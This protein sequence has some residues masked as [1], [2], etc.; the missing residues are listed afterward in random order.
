MLTTGKLGLD[1]GSDELAPRMTE[2]S[3]FPL[4]LRNIWLIWYP[5]WMNF[6]LRAQARHARVVHPNPE[7]DAISS[8]ASNQ[9]E[10]IVR[11]ILML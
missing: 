4:L 2:D 9:F 5:S 10:S 6:S 7:Y 8:R 11:V 1:M 3:K